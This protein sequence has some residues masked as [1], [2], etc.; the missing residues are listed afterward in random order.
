MTIELNEE[1]RT[2]LILVLGMAMATAASERHGGIDGKL[3][4]GIR[5]LVGKISP[6]S[7]WAL[8]ADE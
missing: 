4:Q 1:E 5:Q 7:Y 2:L 8:P 6:A 3:G